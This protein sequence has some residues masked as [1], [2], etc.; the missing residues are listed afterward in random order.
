[1]LIMRI[2]TGSIAEA[3]KWI[4]TFFTA[5]FRSSLYCSSENSKALLCSPYVEPNEFLLSYGLFN[6]NTVNFSSMQLFWNLTQSA[7]H[8]CN[9]HIGIIR[10]SLILGTILDSALSELGFVV[11]Q[12]L[13]GMVTHRYVGMVSVI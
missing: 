2:Y 10:R 13:F 9:E 11:F 5:Y 8:F 3:V 7:P 6:A 4:P 12:T 1:M